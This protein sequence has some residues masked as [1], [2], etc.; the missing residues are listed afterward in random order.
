MHYFIVILL[1]LS[2]F[3]I[4]LVGRK[5]FNIN[6]LKNEY[7]NEIKQVHVYEYD[8]NEIKEKKDEEDEE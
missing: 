4:K 2:K 1:D 6:V 5:D 7:E 8:I 3:E